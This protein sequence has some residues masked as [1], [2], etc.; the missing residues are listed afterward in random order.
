MILTDHSLLATNTDLM[1]NISNFRG[2]KITFYH[3]IFTS[4]IYTCILIDAKQLVYQGTVISCAIFVW[5]HTKQ[6]QRPIP[7]SLFRTTK[8]KKKTGLTYCQKAQ[9]IDC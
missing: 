3:A 5:Q 1:L 6:D 7:Y 8:E 2:E 4:I 9:M